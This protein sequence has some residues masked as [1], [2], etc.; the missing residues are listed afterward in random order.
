MDV[1]HRGLEVVHL[2]D[3]RTRHEER[4]PAIALP[5]VEADPAGRELGDRAHAVAGRLAL[6]F[7]ADPAAVHVGPSPLGVM[8]RG[9]WLPEA[10]QYVRPELLFVHVAGGATR[11]G[12]GG[13]VLLV[14]GR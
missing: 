8:L 1:A 12:V 11:L 4:R 5:P 3:T 9:A 6:V 2:A 14:V 10:S 13:Q 7:I